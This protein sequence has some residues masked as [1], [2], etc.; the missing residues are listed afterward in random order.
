MAN[1]S[2][3]AAAAVAKQIAAASQE[4][5]LT[6]DDVAVCYKVLTG[7]DPDDIVAEQRNELQNHK[8][9]VRIHNTHTS[10]TLMRRAVAIAN[11]IEAYKEQIIEEDAERVEAYVYGETQYC[12]DRGD[13]FQ[14]LTQYGLLFAEVP[15]GWAQITFGGE[16]FQ[17]P[18][19]T[20]EL[21]PR[22]QYELDGMIKDAKKL[23]NVKKIQ[24]VAFKDSPYCFVTFTKNTNV[25]YI[26]Y[27]RRDWKEIEPVAA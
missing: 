25:K 4:H 6:M 16:D 10:G 2:T 9:L 21:S 7:L 8:E 11:E 14:M 17:N 3:E 19:N 15:R 24:V 27:A 23:G 26:C 13:L 20:E 1:K 22:I 18:I 5:E 12:P